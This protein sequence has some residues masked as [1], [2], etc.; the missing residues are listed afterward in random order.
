MNPKYRTVR[1]WYDK[2]RSVNLGSRFGEGILEDC[3]TKFDTS[4]A[5]I[6][7]F[8]GRLQKVT[9]R[10]AWDSFLCTAGSSI[11]LR[12][13]RTAIRV[14]PTTIARR[15]PGITR[16]S[17]RMPSGRPA[18]NENRTRVMKRKRNLQLNVESN[19]A[20]AKSHGSGL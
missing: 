3:H 8:L 12:R 6:Q 20:N 7:K 10:N 14:Q 5:S 16:G 4:E 17:K 13:C 19:Q 18:Q 9:T 1:Y 15:R 2:W 11:P